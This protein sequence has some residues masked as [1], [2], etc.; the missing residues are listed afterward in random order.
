MGLLAF[1]RYKKVEKQID[2]NSYYPSLILD[3]LLTIAV[4]VIGLFF[5]IYLSHIF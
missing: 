5:I 3:T 1:I 4:V 2:D